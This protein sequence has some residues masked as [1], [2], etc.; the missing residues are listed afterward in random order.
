M[1]ATA[2]PVVL[3]RGHLENIERELGHVAYLLAATRERPLLPQPEEFIRHLLGTNAVV[4]AALTALPV[5][6]V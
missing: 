2:D 1:S 6:P 5:N 4:S 3:L